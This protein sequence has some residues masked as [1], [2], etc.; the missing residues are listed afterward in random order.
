MNK[1]TYANKVDTKI[2]NSPE[3][4][5]V[6]AST[7][8]EVKTIVNETVDQVVLNLNDIANNV[9]K[10]TGDQSIA[11]IKTF[12][13]D[14]IA[15]T[16]ANATNDTTVATTAYVKNLIGEIPAGLSFESTWNA[17]TDTPDLST[18]APNN[19]Q[20][21]IVSV[22]GATDLSGITDWK[23]GDWAI[24]VTDGAG[25]DGWQKVDNSSVLDGQGTGQTV[26]LWSGSGDSN[27][28]TNSPITVTGN[29]ANFAADIKLGD[30][31]SAYFGSGNDLRIFNSG[32]SSAISS[33]GSLGLFVT[34]ETNLFTVYTT[35]TGG[36]LQKT[37]RADGTNGKVELYFDDT[38]KF[39]T[40]SDGAT[41]TGDLTVSN[42]IKLSNSSFLTGR[43]FGDTGDVLLIGLDANDKVKIDANG[44]GT[45]I[46]SNLE[47]GNNLTVGGDIA[48]GN[49]EWLMGRNVED[50]GDVLLIGLD[51]NNK[52]KIDANFY[53]TLISGDAT[54][55]NDLTVNGELSVT[56]AATFASSLTT[57][58]NVG[59]GVVP[60][61]GGSTW[62]HLQFGG[63]G[64]LIS[65]ASSGIDATFANNF[66]VNSSN[67]DSYITTGEA[68]R[69]FFN[70]DVIS[71]DQASSG[72]ADSAIT[73]TEALKLNADQ[74]ATFASSVSATKATINGGELI[75]SITDFATKSN[76]IFKLA[77]PSVRLG[78]GYNSAD[79]PLIQGFS[80]TNAVKNVSLNPYGG[81]V[82][83]GTSTN[84]GSKLQVNG[85]ATFASSVSATKLNI[86]KNDN[87]IYDPT[88]DDGQ[89]DAGGTIYLNNDSTTVNSFSQIMH[90]SRASGQAVARIVFLDK[91]AGSS[92]IAFVTEGAETK[93]QALILNSDKSA[94]FASS[95]SATDLTLSKANTPLFQLIDTT[96][97]VSLLF[98]ADDTNTFLRSSSGS[99]FFQT[100]GGTSALTLAQDQSATFASS[101]TAN[102]TLIANN[103]GGAKGVLQI[104]GNQANFINYEISNA[105]NGIDNAGLQIINL[106]SD[107]KVLY[108]NSSN[109]ATFASSVSATDGIFSGQTFFGTTGAPNGT[110]VYGSAF[111]T[112]SS[113]RKTLFQA[114]STTAS[115]TMQ[116]FFNPNGLVGTIATSG[117]ATSYNT[118]SDYRL[119]ED[120]QDFNGLEMISNIP[121]YD[122]KWKVDES[123][124]YG[125]MA[126][127]LQEVLP[128]AVSGEKDAE[129]MQ[130]VDYSKIVPL[131]VKSIQELK[132]EIEL[133]KNK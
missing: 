59:V 7:L 30:N 83:I 128:N 67:V 5:K 57:G 63:A 100:N 8:N 96:N 86:I 60:K 104:K 97:N 1:I 111:I 23:V 14:V 40:S 33:A 44:L 126:H 28:L 129:E 42:N 65:R 38:K 4:N 74:S 81:N 133:L 12:T 106:N 72:S 53:G 25:A 41:L 2:V 46:S 45:L 80:S 94:T 22:N 132:A 49:T 29:D 109:Q 123:R 110:S 101:V 10:I 85:S 47:V 98:G 93:G 58:G 115:S 16:K 88:N 95:V 9:V 84:N 64:N 31:N 3:I 54:V 87:T 121:V 82:L 55:G 120:L 114:T 37:I 70:N 32:T 69:M 6:T 66:Y 21:W 102:G 125:V 113:N 90:D 131:L 71:F 112:N 116:A 107:T 124:S 122:Y 105:I 34:T 26:P 75:A 11:G 99:I 73:W 36:G 24:Y 27:T 13:G 19:G 118:S 43:D 62:R 91:G 127:E 77:N 50:T 20:F 52:V 56:Q 15:T 78:I 48:L 117:S 18:A 119:K 79:I 92:A 17:D 68:S 89:R 130:G 39:E 108:F 35:P 61:T 103:T 51:T 76:T